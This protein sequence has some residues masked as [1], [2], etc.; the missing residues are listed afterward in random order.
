MI[1]QLIGA[2]LF[3]QG[4][5]K[6]ALDRE[7]EELCK[8]D[9]GVKIYETVKLPD[10]MFDQWGEPFPGWRG[11][12]PAER[13]SA[14]YQYTIEEIYLKK[15]NPEKGEGRLEKRIERIIRRSNGTLLG[16]AIEYGRSGGDLIPYAHPSSKHCPVYKSDEEGLLKSVFKRG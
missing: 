9:G 6:F 3:L 5:E 10:A 8:K 14:D 4:C 13:L 15:G 11:R 2:S 7:M 16:E 1:F 12:S